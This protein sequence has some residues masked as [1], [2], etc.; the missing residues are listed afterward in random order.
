VITR[1]LFLF[2][3]MR[4]SLSEASAR[5]HVSILSMITILTGQ[6]A[7]SFLWLEAVLVIFLLLWFAC[8]Q[9]HIERVN[10]GHVGFTCQVAIREL[11]IWLTRAAQ[12]ER[13]REA[14]TGADPSPCLLYPR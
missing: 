3:M 8:L 10:I 9:F 14:S 2:G 1:V 5:L 4:V 11:L 6:V 12:V 7:S 13:L